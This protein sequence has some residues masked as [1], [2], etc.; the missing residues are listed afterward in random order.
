MSRSSTSLPSASLTHAR[1]REI[2]ASAAVMP[3]AP[4]EPPPMDP[5]APGPCPPPA[6]DARPSPPAKE[7]GAG[8][9]GCTPGIDEYD[10]EEAP[11]RL[12][13]DEDAPPPPP[14]PD[15]APPRPLGP[16][17]DARRD[18]RWLEGDPGSAPRTP[19]ADCRA[20]APENSARLPPGPTTPPPPSAS[21]SGFVHLPPISSH[22]ALRSL[23]C[24]AR[25]S[26]IQELGT[27]AKTRFRFYFFLTEDST[28]LSGLLSR[29]RG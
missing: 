5:R 21:V 2:S 8:T 10:A 19:S 7:N 25:D 3:R 20:A 22:R 17:A 14:G 27:W 28:R 1:R 26:T 18:P 9:P 6:E 11:P 23:L 16:S 12:L 13:N 24:G 4:R 29:A 15:D